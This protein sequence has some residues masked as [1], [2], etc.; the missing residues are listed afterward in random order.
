M[1]GYNARHLI[2]RIAH[3]RCGRLPGPT[4]ACPLAST[5][6]LR[7]GTRNHGRSPYRPIP[8]PLGQG[9]S[10]DFPPLGSWTGLPPLFLS[11]RNRA[12]PVGRPP[13]D[14]RRLSLPGSTPPGALRPPSPL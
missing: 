2:R 1:Q 11:L 6:P 12:S 4:P 13:V 8:P 9:R 7:G 10:A 3:R 5:P 14:I